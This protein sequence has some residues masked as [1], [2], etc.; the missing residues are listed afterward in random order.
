[1]WIGFPKNPKHPLLEPR[2]ASRHSTP[3]EILEPVVRQ[4]GIA[5]RVLDI[6]MPEPSLQGSGVVPRVGN[7]KVGRS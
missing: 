5:N 4:L 2:P 7:A 3:P 6:P 1:M